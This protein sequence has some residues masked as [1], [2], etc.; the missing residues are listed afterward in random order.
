MHDFQQYTVC[1]NFHEDQTTSVYY[2]MVVTELVKH[3]GS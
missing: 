2:M 3:V 1:T